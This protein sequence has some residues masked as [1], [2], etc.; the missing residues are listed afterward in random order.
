M[1]NL[2]VVDQLFHDCSQTELS[3]HKFGQTGGAAEFQQHME[4]ESFL[5]KGFDKGHS[6]E[7]Q[8]LLNA[9][10]SQCGQ[11][12]SIGPAVKIID[13]C[14]REVC[15]EEAVFSTLLEHPVDVNR[16]RLFGH[17]AGQNHQPGPVMVVFR[18]QRLLQAESV[19]PKNC[20]ERVS[21]FENPGDGESDFLACFFC[22]STSQTATPFPV[23]SLRKGISTTL[24]SSLSTAAT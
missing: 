24:L 11:L 13:N 22:R 8:S 10:L 21:E 2:A 4:R 3:K 7:L 23:V 5:A 18:S 1:E 17:R 15:F 12:S 14:K 6:N 9:Q 19:A 16:T 20:A